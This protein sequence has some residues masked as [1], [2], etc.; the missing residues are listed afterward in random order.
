MILDDVNFE[1]QTIADEAI[2]AEIDLQYDEFFDTMMAYENMMAY[3]NAS[4][5]A[6]AIYY[7]EM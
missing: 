6:D 4:Y 7:G 3:A 1:L 2:Q 5:D